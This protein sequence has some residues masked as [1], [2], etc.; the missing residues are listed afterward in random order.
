LSAVRKVIASGL[1][2]WHLQPLC[3]VAPLFQQ[4]VL[5]GPLGPETL[6]HRWVNGGEEGMEEAWWCSRLKRMQ[7]GFT[8]CGWGR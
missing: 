7:G 3:D 2:D 1:G 6:H 8:G 4:R 5:L